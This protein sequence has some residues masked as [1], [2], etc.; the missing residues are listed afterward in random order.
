M[1]KSPPATFCPPSLLLAPD[2]PWW[3]GCAKSA[4]RT[5]SGPVLR[6]P[7]HRPFTGP[8]RCS[9][10]LD[11]PLQKRSPAD[12]PLMDQISQAKA[13][14]QAGKVS[15]LLEPSYLGGREAGREVGLCDRAATMRH[16]RDSSEQPRV[17]L[18]HSP[19]YFSLKTRLVC[20][21]DTLLNNMY[22]AN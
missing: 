14:R 1:W 19:L 17:H 8:Y 2:G 9:A 11:L 5:R 15:Q 18:I 16:P 22:F 10:W 12:P 4:R 13:P 20:N 3:P 21:M 6:D 7:S